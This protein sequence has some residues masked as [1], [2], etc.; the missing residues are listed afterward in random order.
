MGDLVVKDKNSKFKESEI[1]YLEPDLFGFLIPD[2]QINKTSPLRIIPFVSINNFKNDTQLITNKG[3]FDRSL[4]REYFNEKNEIIQDFDKK[5]QALANEEIFGDYYYYTITIELDRVGKSEVDSE[6]KYLLPKDQIYKEAENRKQMIK[7]LMNIISEFTRD[8]KHQTIH[9]KP[10][11][12]YGGIFKKTIPYFWNDMK[13]KEG[14]LNI[15]V[16]NRTVEDYNLENEG[17]LIGAVDKER[18]SNEI[19]GNDEKLGDRPIL[20]IKNICKMIEEDKLTIGEDN[21][22]YLEV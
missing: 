2:K 3:Y 1:N 15:N 18:L 20:A 22:W 7:D 4:G 10:L 21:F 8:I 14:K 16:F 19:V 9:L 13:F 5:T 12:V 6:G 11:V 17:F